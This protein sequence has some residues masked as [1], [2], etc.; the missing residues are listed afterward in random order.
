MAEPI[1]HP[2]QRDIAHP[3][4]ADGCGRRATVGPMGVPVVC[5][6]CATKP[7][8][9]RPVE[10]RKTSAEQALKYHHDIA[11]ADRVLAEHEIVGILVAGPEPDT[12]ECSCGH[13]APGDEFTR[14][15]AAQVVLALLEDRS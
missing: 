6:V 15:Q 4:C 12:Y 13:E 8:D 2:S 7:R 9:H 14:H 11:T 3:V 10:P 5:L 1:L